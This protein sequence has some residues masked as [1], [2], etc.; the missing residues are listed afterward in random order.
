MQ[1]NEPFLFELTFK[2]FVSLRLPQHWSLDNWSG[3]LCC[4]VSDCIYSLRW[5]TVHNS[6]KYTFAANASVKRQRDK[7]DA[8]LMYRNTRTHQCRISNYLIIRA[9]CWPLNGHDLFAKEHAFLLRQNTYAAKCIFTCTAPKTTS[10]LI[11][12]NVIASWYQS[13]AADMVLQKKIC[14]CNMGHASF[15]ADGSFGTACLH[16]SVKSWSANE[17]GINSSF[18]NIVSLFGTDRPWVVPM[19]TTMSSRP[20]VLFSL[21]IKHDRVKIYCCQ[22]ATRS[23]V[24]RHVYTSLREIVYAIHSNS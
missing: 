12:F 9:F 7:N 16:Q 5:S 13:L 19:T 15:S 21:L 1:S 23:S 8:L 22:E 14:A 11:L 24:Y 20:E 2:F 4:Q 18:I 6:S 3:R 10:L 17:C